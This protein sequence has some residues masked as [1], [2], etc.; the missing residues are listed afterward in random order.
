M[1]PRQLTSFKVIV[2]RQVMER[3]PRSQMKNGLLNLIGAYQ[4]QSQLHFQS[5]TSLNFE[6]GDNVVCSSFSFIFLTGG[7]NAGSTL[8]NIC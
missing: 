4:E 2:Q 1:M 3:N 7:M 5:F 8:A 6:P